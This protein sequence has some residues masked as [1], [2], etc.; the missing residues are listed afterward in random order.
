MEW[1]D[2]T[3]AYDMAP[4]TWIIERVKTYKIYNKIINFITNVMENWRVELTA[5]VV[6]KDK[7]M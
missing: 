3:K 2:Y 1:I 6:Y 4:K 7:K 5:V